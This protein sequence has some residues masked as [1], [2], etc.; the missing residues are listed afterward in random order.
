MFLLIDGNSIANRAFYGMRPL[1]N[2]YGVP[3]GAVTGFISIYLKLCKTFSPTHCAVC[4]DI[5]RRT[6]RN[7]IY[8]D[9]KGTRH[10]TPQ[11]L[12]DQLAVIRDLCP[13]LGVRAL[14]FQGFEADDIIGTLARLCTENK[15]D[16]VISTGDRDSFQLINEFT[17]VNYAAKNGDILYGPELL[18]A[19]KG[20]TPAQV[21]ELKSL[22]G[23]ASDNIPGVKGIGEKTALSLLTQYG[24]LEN[25]IDAAARG[26]VKGSSGRKINENA[27]TAR[28]C[29]RLAEI[30]TDVPGVPR[31]LETYRIT[32]P[33]EDAFS[34]L[35]NLEM[36]SSIKKLREYSTK[37]FTESNTN[38][39]QEI[40]KNEENKADVNLQTPAKPR[41]IPLYSTFDV[42][43]E[44]ADALRRLSESETGEY[45][46]FARETSKEEQ[47]LELLKKTE[48]DVCIASYLLGRRIPKSKEEA[49]PEELYRQLRNEPVLMSLMTDIELPLA[50]VL[51]EME[52]T[53]F[54]LNTVQ[55]I[56]FGEL[57]KVTQKNIDEKILKI[58]AEY[59][60]DGAA[61]FN[62]DSP[63]QTAHLLYDIMKLS[64]GAKTTAGGRTTS[65]EHLLHISDEH[66][67]AGLILEHRKYSKLQGT[68]VAGLLKA[69]KV[70]QDGTFR[71]HTT[72]RQTETRTGRI[73]SA[74]PNL[75]NLPARTEA[76]K[77]IRKAFAA[78]KG[79]SLISADYSQIELRVLA[80]LS[81][82]P[83]MVE[84]FNDDKDIH[85]M[86]ASV[87][88]SRMRPRGEI[89]EQKRAMAKTIN[90]GVIYGMSAFTLSK[91]LKVPVGAAKN[92]IDNFMESYS[93][94]RDFLNKTVE[95]AEKTGF[96]TT[97]Y[98]RK[99]RVPELRVNRTR[100]AGRR[101]AL[102]TPIQG[103]A[104]DIIKLA[105]LRVHKRLVH[106]RE[107]GLFSR[108]SDYARLILQIHDELIIECPDFACEQI[109][110]I[111]RE[112]MEQAVEPPRKLIVPLTVRVSVGK[113]L[114]SCK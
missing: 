87:L 65:A 14:A 12:R 43:T 93:A 94:A 73:S 64:A 17:S 13:S 70:E 76:G 63:Q 114:D 99:R 106:E 51:A 35:E 58:A 55:L 54:E 104:A 102:N 100:S 77:N 61:A 29:R 18:F 53:G 10:E 23:D 16:C 109:M 8:D 111:V 85:F 5:A 22:M 36:V 96:V 44:Y 3:T 101:I 24:T 28:M 32:A 30:C 46:L 48:F 7:E 42:K 38:E 71:V 39:P 107:N 50:F 89:T 33:T 6:F 60:P 69:A 37:Y 90:F 82:D 34:I 112:E 4:F 49:E 15:K 105:M 92:Y 75:Q 25:I 78:R 9:Y 66:P 20:Y 88:F 56:E 1:S 97:M 2:S 83:I 103:T 81:A 67:I 110:E 98:G 52:L 27:D 59:D 19:E 62:I 74:E 79:Y 113:N 41:T 108:S 80:H 91:Q 11:E 26:T 45:T 84:I 47:K 95:D 72:Y 21:V 68:Y 86:T 40:P 57:I 31:E